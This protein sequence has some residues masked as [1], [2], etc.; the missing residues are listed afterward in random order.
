MIGAPFFVE[1]VFAFG[2]STTFLSLKSVFFSA[3]FAWIGFETS[4]L[5]SVGTSFLT[6]A[7]ASF[8]RFKSMVPTCLGAETTALA[9]ITSC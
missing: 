6:A 1:A 8:L 9:L 4:A 3:A 2:A 5:T 7:L